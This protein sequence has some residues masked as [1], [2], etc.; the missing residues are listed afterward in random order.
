DFEEYLNLQSRTFVQYY[1]C[2]ST[3]FLNRE[4]VDED[5]NRV[6]MPASALDRLSR[7]NIDFPMMFQIQKPSTERVTHCSVLEFVAE[8]GFIHMPSWV[9]AHLGV[10]ENELVLVRSTSLP[11][12][13]F[14]KLQ[15]HTTAFLDVPDQ[16]EL[17]EY[18]FR[19]FPC[20][21]A[22]ETIAV[23]KGERRYYLDVLEARPADAVCT[24][25]TDC[26][27][28]FA[29]PLDY[30]EP[31][32]APAPAPAPVASQG[33]GE[34]P[35]FTGVAARMDGKLVER[36]P[37][38]APVPVGR[39]GDQPRRP[40]QFTGVAVRLDGKSVE[41]PQPPMPS[42][43]AA[44]ADALGALKKRMARFAAPSAVGSDVSK[45][46]AAGGKEQEK[47]FAGTRYS[48]KD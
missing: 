46:E 29:T 27:V 41:M 6:I 26:E 24:M 37:T 12:A 48:L 39:Q 22:G 3:S 45:A 11:T 31:P 30:V 2:L 5:G 47:R 44:S 34:P 10:E 18:N 14:L 15:P 9:M 33:S 36:Q 23:T 17:L 32:R 42:P 4:N 40:A 16:R 20:L 1:H 19:K 28:D 35:R 13:T 25:D 43:A 8:E 38:P 21:T 7:L